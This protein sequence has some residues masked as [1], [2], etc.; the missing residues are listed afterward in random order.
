MPDLKTHRGTVLYA[1]LAYVLTEGGNGEV[2]VPVFNLGIGGVQR[3]R[4]LLDN[5][6]PVPLADKVAELAGA[7]VQAVTLSMSFPDGT[8]AMTQPI[9]LDYVVLVAWSE[10]RLLDVMPLVET[11]WHANRTYITVTALNA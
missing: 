4:F 9:P 2:T 7:T 3:G 10:K 8:T 1:K 6:S 5:D 11:D